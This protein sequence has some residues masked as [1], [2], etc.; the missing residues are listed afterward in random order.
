VTPPSCGHAELTLHDH[1]LT[2][3]IQIVGEGGPKDDAL[4]NLAQLAS[5]SSANLP[6][7]SQVPIQPYPM[8]ISEPGPSTHPHGPPNLGQRPAAAGQSQSSEPENEK[9]KPTDSAQSKSQST[10][11]TTTGRSRNANRAAMGSDEWARQRKDNHVSSVTLSLLRLL[12]TGKSCRK[13]WSAVGVETSTR[14][15]MN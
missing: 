3:F 13:K 6:S 15:S 12:I 14:A 5:F 10:N 1:I 4:A 11:S 2:G 9:E 8:H 7:N